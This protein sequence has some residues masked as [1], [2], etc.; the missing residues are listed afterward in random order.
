[1][2][3]FAISGLYSIRGTRRLLDELAKVF[4]ACSTGVMLIIILI[5]F[6]RELF[7]SRFIILAGWVLSIVFVSVARII[8]RV[9]QH[10]LLKRGIGVHAIALIGSDPAT[11]ELAR[12]FQRRPSL[13]YRV[14]VRAQAVSE[15]LFHELERNVA[16]G[17]L[18]EVLV[19]DSAIPKADVVKLIEFASDHHKTF[20]YAPD[21]FET[22]AASLEVTAL[23]GVPIIELRRTPLDGW[24]KILKQSVDVLGAFLGL[25]VFLPFGLVIATCIK[26]DSPG[27]V[28]VQLQRVGRAGRVFG[29]YKFRSMVQNAEAL[30]PQLQALNERHDG[31]LFK[32]KDDPRITRFGRFLRKTSIDEIP[33]FWNVLRGEMSLVGPRPHEPQ[34]VARYARSQRALLTVKPGV[35]GLAQI[36][37]RSNL[38]FEEEVRLDTY[39]IEH[40]SLQLDLQILSKTPSVVFS[41]RAAA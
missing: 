10:Q 19:A 11:E 16:A 22:Q 3:V 29:L 28:F 13:G 31:P 17:T 39:Y 25:L 18:D 14:S 23:G 35:T 33:Q 6:Q 32:L 21:R 26:L 37:G 5:F 2:V 15:S 40:W 27:P 9:V 30:K 34:E 20:K 36:S 7:S 4:V 38:R 24:G 41:T 12:D 1:M 8:A